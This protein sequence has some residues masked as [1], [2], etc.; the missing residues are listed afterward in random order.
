VL[1]EMYKG[2]LYKKETL[3]KGEHFESY[4]PSGLLQSDIEF[5][6]VY[7][8]KFIHL[9]IFFY[10]IYKNISEHKEIQLLKQHI[11]KDSIV[12]D[13]GANIGFYTLIF[14]NLVGKNGKVI[15]FEPDSKNFEIL[16]KRC[17][18]RKNVLLVQ[19]ALSDKTGSLDFYLSDELNV[20]HRAYPTE[21]NRKK[22]TVK[23]YSLDDFLQEHNIT[24]V[25]FIKTDL[26]GF[27]PIAIRGMKETI[28]SNLSHIKLFCEFWP[29]GMKQAG[30]SP[31]EWLE[32]MKALG[33][34]TNSKY[35]FKY[36]K[37]YYTSLLFEKG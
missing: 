26:Q 11:T 30:L 33:L 4:Y 25:N 19:A 37:E 10:I 13:A 21:E 16:Q 1:G 36:E 7:K 27:D 31:Q 34:K 14:S 2:V 32:E 28:K 22:I 17:L 5:N 3:V 6:Y 15:A 24:K 29:Y 9:Y 20:D 12:I 35:E 8:L 18:S 23:A